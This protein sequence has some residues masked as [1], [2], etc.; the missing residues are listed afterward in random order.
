MKKVLVVLTIMAMFAITGCTK[1]PEAHCAQAMDHVMELMMKD[2]NI[3][4][5]PKEQVA[6]MKE[7]FKKQKEKGVKECAKDYKK[8]AVECVISAGSMKDMAKCDKKK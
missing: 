1:S 8:D 6:K 7:G 3:K 4:K 2:P 5:M